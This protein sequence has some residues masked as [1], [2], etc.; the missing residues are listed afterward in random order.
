MLLYNVGYMLVATEAEHPTPEAAGG[1]TMP[2][3]PD[4]LRRV[5]AAVHGDKEA[6]GSGI[7]T[8]AIKPAGAAADA[9]AGLSLATIHH[10]GEEA[11]DEDIRA[12]MDAMPCLVNY[13]GTLRAH[14]LNAGGSTAAIILKDMQPKP[15]Q[16]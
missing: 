1:I 5:Y 10:Y 9:K 2:E 4:A 11:A 13:G 8:D 7:P 12:A 16:P 15:A 6:D 14:N 3:E